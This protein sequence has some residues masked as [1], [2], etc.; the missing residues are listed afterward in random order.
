MEKK[1]ALIIFEL[2]LERNVSAY[3]DYVERLASLL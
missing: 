1:Q 2:Y 3:F